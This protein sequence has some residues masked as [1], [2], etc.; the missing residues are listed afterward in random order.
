MCQSPPCIYPR[1]NSSGAYTLRGE[2]TTHTL[3]QC[4]M[5]YP[6]KALK[7]VC[8]CLT[9]RGGEGQLSLL[10]VA[11]RVD[12]GTAGITPVVIGVVPVV[13]V[14]EESVVNSSRDGR[15]A[16]QIWVLLIHRL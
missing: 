13:K 8:V 1:K 15:Y 12:V 4:F 7:Y 10:T 6:N 2:T 3:I 14:Y 5:V 11:Y 9:S 16:D